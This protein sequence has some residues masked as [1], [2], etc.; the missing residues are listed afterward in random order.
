[1]VPINFLI[2]LPALAAL[3]MFRIPLIRLVTTQPTVFAVANGFLRNAIPRNIGAA[4]NRNC[5]N[6]IS[7][8]SDMGF[9]RNFVNPSNADPTRNDVTLNTNLPIAIRP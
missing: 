5:P 8:F 9:S 3:P 4:D 1:M 6:P 2:L 7:P